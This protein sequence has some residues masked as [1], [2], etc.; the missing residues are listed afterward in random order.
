MRSELDEMQRQHQP[1]DDFISQFGTPDSTETTT[2]W[3][4]LA[5][6]HM[7]AE[8]W[9]YHNLTRDPAS[10]TVDAQT[11]VVVAEISDGKKFIYSVQYN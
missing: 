8:R 2:A 11:V 6:V 9:I 3:H 5:K 7:K 1:A 10:Q 4:Y